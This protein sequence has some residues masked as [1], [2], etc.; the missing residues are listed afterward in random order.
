MPPASGSPIHGGG[1]V[2]RA[3][4]MKTAR[5]ARP[6]EKFEPLA[7]YPPGQHRALAIFGMF[8]PRSLSSRNPPRAKT[9]A[10]YRSNGP[11]QVLPE[12]ARHTRSAEHTSELQ[13]QSNIVCRLLL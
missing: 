7:Q 3:P 12:I 2:R 4:C 6:D 9:A 13:S 11:M 8:L 10:R 1:P 5:S